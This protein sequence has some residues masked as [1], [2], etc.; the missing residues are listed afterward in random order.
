PH[1]HNL[2]APSVK[3]SYALGARDIIAAPAYVNASARDYRPVQTSPAVDNGTTAAS[4]TDLAGNP[5]GVGL[6]VDIGA[7]ELQTSPS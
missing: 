7:H 2:F 6:G 3:V 1:D 4:T 5:T